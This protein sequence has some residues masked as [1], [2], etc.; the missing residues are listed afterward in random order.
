MLNLNKDQDQT[1]TITYYPQ[2]K[3]HY[4]N[5]PLVTLQIQDNTPKEPESEATIIQIDNKPYL[6][7]QLT[8]QIIP[9]DLK[10]FLNQEQTEH[11]TKR[12]N[13]ENNNQQVQALVNLHELTTMLHD[14]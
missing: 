7:W 6:R 1:A 2:E 3:D 5:Q 14:Q 12:L 4:S 11:I 13:K 10:P 9:E 8:T